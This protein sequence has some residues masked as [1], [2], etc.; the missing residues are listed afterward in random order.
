MAPIIEA[1][2]WPT[3]D[4]SIQTL[5]K[6][7]GFAGRDADPSGAASIEWF[8]QWVRSRIPETRQRILDYSEDDCRATRVMLDGLRALAPQAA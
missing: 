3:N 2:E 1:T 4:Q 6:Y 5:A 7:L 8:D